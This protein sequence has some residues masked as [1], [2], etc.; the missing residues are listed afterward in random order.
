MVTKT[1]IYK[2]I[3]A[4]HLRQSHRSLSMLFIHSLLSKNPWAEI[5]EGEKV[6]QDVGGAP[7]R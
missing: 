1:I 5:L 2:K 3:R 4:K 7:A 6:V